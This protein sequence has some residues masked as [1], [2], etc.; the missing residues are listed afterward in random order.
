MNLDAVRLA[1]VFLAGTVLGLFY[2][3][4][5]WLTLRR[6]HHVRQP[7]VLLFTSFVVRIAA[8]VPAFYFV[9]AGHWERIVACLA[10]F[11]VMRHLMIR[12]SRPI[13]MVRSTIGRTSP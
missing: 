5:L 7:G 12:R 1:A 2:F 13:D 11:L 6:I 3:G 4:G 9:M 8:V 10:G